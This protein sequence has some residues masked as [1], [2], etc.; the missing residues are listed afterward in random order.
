MSEE[1]RVLILCYFFPPLGG[2]GVHR[3][4][5]FARHL[6][7]HGWS[8][9]VVCAGADDYW[10]RDE[11]L[12][13]PEGTEVLRVRGGSGLTTWLKAGGA[14]GGRR[15]G[16]T[17]GLLRRLSD[18]WLLPD[19]YRGWAR[20]ARA[21]A[22]ARVRR[23]DVRALLSSSPPESVQLAARDV[24]RRTGLPWIADFRDPWVPLAFRRP[25]SAWHRA[26]QEA[27]ERS[28]LMEADRVI[29]ASRT[30][31]EALRERLGPAADARVVHV[32]NGWEPMAEPTP[33]RDP[34]DRFLV[35]FTGTIAQLPDTEVALEAVHELLAR[36]PDARRRLR[37]EL[38]GPYESGYE[39]RAVAL[40]LTGIVRFTGPR[41][42]QEVRGLQR[43]ADLLLL[44]NPHG[45]G[46]RTMVPGKLYEYLETG[47]PIVALLPESHEA[48]ELARRGGAT[49]LPPGRREPLTDE[50]ERRYR[51][52][53][54]HGRAADEARPWLAEHARPVLAGRLAA[55][56]NDV[57]RAKVS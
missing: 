22:A 54:E 41:P 13:V 8:C 2:G 47:R 42:H 44:W 12:T 26:R 53:R 37:V 40:G 17:F 29:V 30:H 24:A 11:T 43:R 38:V 33:R 18:W 31:A 32:P 4:L 50:L 20:R 16:S 19:S 39:D 14:A 25:P 48:A 57:A 1:L 15:S 21:V 51:A 7:A 49:I 52:W 5:S 35:V 34:D 46:Y 27:L 10:V 3:V 55:V 28:V 23:G 9:T 36:H 6:P 56:L 45:P